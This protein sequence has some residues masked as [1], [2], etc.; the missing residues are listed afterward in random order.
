MQ[1]AEDLEVGSVEHS[2][3]TYICEHR[4]KNM[5]GDKSPTVG[6][7]GV[8]EQSWR[9]HPKGPALLCLDSGIDCSGEGL[10]SDISSVFEIG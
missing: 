8:G 3:N 7:D 2:S 4:R 10:Y 5:V 1:G 6:L 9:A